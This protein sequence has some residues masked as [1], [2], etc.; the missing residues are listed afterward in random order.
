[1]N[2]SH[3]LEINLEFSDLIDS[4][5]DPLFAKN[6]FFLK[7]D[8]WKD[9]RAEIT[10]AFTNNRLK[11]LYPLAQEILERLINYTKNHA[12][13]ALE[14]RELCAKYTVD[15]VSSCIYGIDAGSFKSENPEIRE[16]GRKLLQP[17]SLVF[18]KLIVKTS[19]PVL[20]K[21]IKIQFSTKEVQD[22]FTNLMNQALEYREKNDIHREDFLD[23]IINLKKKKNISHIEMASHTI[24][25]FTD[26]FETSSIAISHAIYEVMTFF[27]FL[28][29]LI[30]IAFYSSPTTR[31]CKINYGWRSTSILM[32]MEK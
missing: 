21:Y 18:F 16:M 5:T 20:T 23:Y 7:D 3:F 14:A 4:E 30:K 17:S 9:K 29:L 6:P 32:K 15:V 22:F 8:E 19:F 26:G 27:S 25:F 12:N 2:F 31:E 28:I 24:S 13:E 10:P 1:M 11:A